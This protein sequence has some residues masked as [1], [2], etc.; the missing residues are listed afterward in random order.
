M[1]RFCQDHGIKHEIC[2]KLVVAT[3]DAE[4]VRLKAL[5][6]RGKANGLADLRWLDAASIREREPYAAG[7]AAVHVPE[8]GIVDYPAVVAKLA[9][10]VQGQGGEI[11]C[12]ERSSAA[13]VRVPRLSWLRPGKNTKQSFF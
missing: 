12:Q 4:V 2:G 9:E 6:E 11:H 7:V 10:L 3:N 8:E 5:L 1:V 13:S